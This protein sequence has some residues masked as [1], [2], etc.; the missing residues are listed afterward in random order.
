MNAALKS[1]LPYSQVIFDSKSITLLFAYS[2]RK[3]E[4]KKTPTKIF[5]G[6]RVEGFGVNFD[7]AAERLLPLGCNF[8]QHF[9]SPC[10]FNSKVTKNANAGKIGVFLRE[11]K[12]T[13]KAHPVVSF[14]GLAREICRKYSCK[15]EK[16]VGVCC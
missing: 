13:W 6:T 11:L 14:E 8:F 15:Y 7:G 12:R 1:I 10:F 16:A 3:R 9:Y 4:K 2:K 5:P